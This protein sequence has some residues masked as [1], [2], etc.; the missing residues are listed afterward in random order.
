MLGGMVWDDIVWHIHRAVDK[1]K[2]F[3]TNELVDMFPKLLR[4]IRE[5]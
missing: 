3:T 2:L 4:R 1:D 5:G